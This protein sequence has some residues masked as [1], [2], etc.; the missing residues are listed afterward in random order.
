MPPGSR[1]APHFGHLSGCF[2]KRKRCRG[3]TGQASFNLTQRNAFR[4]GKRLNKMV[5]LGA[6]L[7]L[8]SRPSDGLNPITAS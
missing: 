7:G 5:N 3:E 4:G 8:L 2:H 6:V 1:N